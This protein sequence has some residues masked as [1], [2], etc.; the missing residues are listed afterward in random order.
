MKLTHLTLKNFRNLSELELIPGDH[1][2]IIYGD[3]AQGKT[4]ILEAI[5]LFTG[6]HSFRG[7]K[8]AELVQFEQHFAEAK[9]TFADEERMQQ[10]KLR[11]GSKRECT[12]NQVP[13][14]ST[15]ELAG[16]F[17]G[18]IFSPDDLDLV[19]GSPAGRRRFLDNAI[20]E[21]RPQY[22]D[23]L[24]K[25]EK[26]LEQRNMLLREIPKTPSLRDTLFIWDQQLAK[27][28]TILHIYRNDYVKKLHRVAASLYQGMT[29]EDALS[30][31]YRSTVF[32]HPEAVVTYEDAHLEAYQKKLEETLENDL[33]FS[34][35]TAGIHRDDLEL[36]L[37]GLSVKNY[38][39]QGQ[40]RS[41]VLLLKLAEAEL[42]QRITG[43]AP[44]ILLDDVM[45][46]LDAGRQ[47]YILNHVKKQQVFITCC[48]IYNTFRLEEGKIFQI[49][50][51]ALVQETEIVLGDGG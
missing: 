24:E 18:V 46:E 3:N 33:R 22:R 27:L 14:K 17:Y 48:D 50:N 6:N 2:N 41:T 10:M 29:G 25:Y 12:L 19:K 49:Q 9:L 51:G 37:K 28:G 40:Q 8:N 44:V 5:W 35:T 16:H 34:H 1:V 20:T 45:S 23:Y 26:V 36:S 32:D 47:H 38:G 11:F 13:L 42:L 43:E 21:L 39:S 7:A 31:S 15:Q 30:V 4:N